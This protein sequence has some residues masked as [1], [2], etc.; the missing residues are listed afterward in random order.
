MA[1]VMLMALILLSSVRW[2]SF[3]ITGFQVA[4]PEPRDYRGLSSVY[5]VV[6][7]TRIT[8]DYSFSEYAEIV[9]DAKE[10]I[11]QCAGSTT[12][13]D[14]VTSH[15]PSGWTMEGEDGPYVMFSV[16]SAY[17]L[18]QYDEATQKVEYKEIEYRFAL[19]FT[20]VG[21]DPGLPVS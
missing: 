4:E 11:T 14:C 21:Y 8:V 7:L 15:L 2:D 12:L 1:M 5:S 10:L 16:K 18:P 13:E 19:D 20:L 3:G 17:K 6:P 9:A